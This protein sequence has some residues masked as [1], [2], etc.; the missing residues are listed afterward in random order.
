MKKF[1]FI[2]LL[3]IS[4]LSQANTQTIGVGAYQKN[5]IY[6]SKN[7]VNM[8][9]IINLEYNNFYLKGY[10]P[11]FIFYKEPDFNLSVIVDPIGGYSDFAIKK[12]QFKDGYKNLNSRN[13]QVMGG[14]AL[15]F[16]FDKNIDGHSEVVF[17]NHGTKVN[18]KFNRPY[19]IND[20]FTFIPAITFN[21]YN[22]RYM[23]YYLGIK[24]KDVQ[25]NEKVERVYKGKD[26]VAG[27]VSTTLDFSLTEQTSFLIF[28][29]VDVY[30]KKIKKSDIVKT[31]NQYY[32]GAG[33]RYSF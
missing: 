4:V 31:N 19:K 27:G 6:H 29:G 22:S 20:R 14:I 2:S 30:D 25:N 12:S 15:D 8:L 5:T 13:T 28:G 24:E 33:L 17:G 18:V 32:I 7:Q 3:A 11:G 1:L 21:Y 26:T 16:K 9:P 10:K 23:N